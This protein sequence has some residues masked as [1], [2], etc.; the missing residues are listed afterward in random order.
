MQSKDL[1]KFKIPSTPGVYFFLRGRDILYIGK[2]TSLRDRTKSYFSKDLIVTRGPSILDMVVQANKID[3][4]KT[5]SVLDALI[6]EA[7][8]IKKHQPKYNVKE[9]DDKSWNYVCITKEEIPKVIIKRGKE[10]RG[11]KNFLETAPRETKGQG[12]HMF[13]KNSSARF[14]DMFGPYTNG[15]QLKEALKIIRKIFP[16]LDDKSKNN[17]EFYKQL[18]LVPE[19]KEIYNNNIK[20]LKLFFEGKKRKILNNLK[21][22]MSIFAKKY[23]FEKANEIKRQIFA[24]QHINDIALIK[25]SEEA[26]LANV[27]ARSST[28]RPRPSQKHLPVLDRIEAYDIAH[29]SGK[30]MVGVM[31]VLERGE[32]TKKEYKKF[33][34]RTQTD[35]NDTGALEEVLS[36][37]FR[38]LE[39][40]LPTLVV[41]DGSVAQINI[42]Q[43]VLNK[44]Q[45]KIPVVG[46]VKDERHKARAIEGDE[47]III[48]NKQAILL[49]NAEAHRF[50]IKFYRAKSRKNLFKN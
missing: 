1:K 25:K 36:R 37:R 14:T 31:T 44:Y 46:V 32:L 17:Y 12:I 11:Q 26:S 35:A 30:N 2:A 41:V 49:A 23:E 4:Q 6:L 9:K 43:R 42:A 13:L 18:N 48:G 50:A 5:D 16:F 34:I 39:W 38:H 8:L 33:I 19:N 40:G 15:G 3:W 47:K 10:L 24:L 21:K 7:E 27:F 29:M 20:N 22:E 45:F 28:Q